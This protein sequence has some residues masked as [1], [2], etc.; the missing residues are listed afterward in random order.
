MKRRRRR[1]MKTALPAVAVGGVVLLV[2]VADSSEPIE[3][4][5]APAAAGLAVQSPWD[6][7]PVEHLEPAPKGSAYIREILM[8]TAA[9][10][11]RYEGR[12]GVDAHAFCLT[13]RGVGSLYRLCRRPRQQRRPDE[14]HGMETPS[15]GQRSHGP[16]CFMWRSPHLCVQEGSL[17]QRHAHGPGVRSTRQSDSLDFRSLMG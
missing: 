17:L 2:A 15:V 7:G 4:T 3:S 12:P 6:D 1:Q 11:D 9:R 10:K 14:G 13:P 16:G 5:I 8:A